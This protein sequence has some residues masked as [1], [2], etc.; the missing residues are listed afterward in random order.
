MKAKIAFYTLGCR[1]NQYDTEM[2]K[3][4][5]NG[6][7]DIE[8]VE[9]SEDADLYIINTCSVTNGADRKSRKYIR[10]ASERGGL[11]LVTGCYATLDREDIITMPEVDVVFTNAYKRSLYEIINK[12]LN[13]FRGEMK[14]GKLSNWDINKERIVRDTS[15]T[16]GFL[17][18][19]DG[20][21]NNCSFCKVKFL[22]G[23]TR[24]KPVSDV[25]AEV[26]SLEDNGFKEV[27]LTGINLA[28]YRNGG[29]GI[30]DLI[31]E[32]DINTRIERIRISS[33]NPQG[34]TRKLVKVFQE[35]DRTCPHFHVPLQ[36]GSNKILDKMNRGYTLEYY[37]HK[38]NLLQDGLK[39]VTFG[40]DL[41]VGFPGEEDQDVKKTEK[42]IA[43]IGYINTHIFRYSPREGTEAS[44]YRGKV[45]SSVKKQRAQRL[46]KLAS[47]V[48]L[49]EREKFLGQPL[50]MIAEEP[51]RYVTGWRGYSKNY[52]DLHIATDEDEGMV[53]EGTLRRAVVTEVTEDRCLARPCEEVE[54]NDTTLQ[55]TS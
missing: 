3:A 43:E 34:I 22:R 17:K 31:E 7:E 4:Q 33:I 28:G 54:E 5:L 21:S 45:Q 26:K 15:H 18:V 12:S 37:L 11:V 6:N 23:P 27:V 30:A 55:A 51:S 25:I 48:S 50:E 42:M 2:M 46:R 52:L 1:A 13:G 16:R 36:S 44:N 53:R 20:C 39:N 40:T 49:K 35:S 10:R 29:S 47:S 24:S 8:L 14:R 19:Q 38:I 41:L 9:F 32:I